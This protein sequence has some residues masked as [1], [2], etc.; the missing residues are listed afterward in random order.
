MLARAFA[1]GVDDI[2]PSTRGR[3][4]AC[5]SARSSG[6]SSCRTRT[7]A[8]RRSCASGSWPLPG[9]SGG[10]LRRGPGQANSELEEANDLLKGTQ[11][12]LVQAAKMA[13]LGELVAASRYE[14]NN[15][16]AFIQAHQGTVARLLTEIAAKLPPE[17]GLERQVQKS[18]D[19]V[20]AM[21]LGLARIQELVLNLRRFS[22]LDEGD[23]QTVNVPNPSRPFWLSWATSSA[24]GSTCAA[25]TMRFP[26]SIARLPC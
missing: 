10:S 11:A 19:R 2:V 15:P 26:T 12:Q 9:T 5:A 16:L 23:F 4:D 1:A 17:V 6:A 13:S 24:P 21:K 7:G 8:S 3:R 22:R 18:R 25:A 14:I 20:G